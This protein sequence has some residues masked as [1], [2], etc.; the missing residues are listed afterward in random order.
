MIDELKKTFTEYWHFLALKTACKLELFDKILSG[1]HTLDLL[2]QHYHYDEKILEFLFGFLFAEGYISEKNNILKLTKKGEILTENHPKSMKYACILWG[3]EH[4][5]AWQNL[6]YTLKTGKPAFNEIFGEKF[7]DFI[8]SKPEKLEI[9]HRAMAEYARDDYE[10][11]CE[12]I[13]FSVHKKIIDVGGGV[14]GTV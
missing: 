9:Y 8:A 1:Y 2:I 12:I 5:T 10:N 13:D 7:F 3:E 6:E 4:L 11:I 14:G